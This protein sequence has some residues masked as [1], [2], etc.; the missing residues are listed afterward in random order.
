MHTFEW[1]EPKLDLNGKGGE[2]P[3]VFVHH[4]GDWSGDAIINI[5]VSMCTI[6]IDEGRIAPPPGSVQRFEITLPAKL[7]ADISRQTTIR[8]IIGR[9]EDMM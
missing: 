2:P 8:D 7:L 4:N 5:P 1:W 6:E 3:T 9:I